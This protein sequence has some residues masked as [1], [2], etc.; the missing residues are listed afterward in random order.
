M[1]LAALGWAYVGQP[2]AS[3]VAATGAGILGA[4][5]L[6]AREYF[7]RHNVEVQGRE[8]ALAPRSVPLERPVGRKEDE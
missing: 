8:A 1:L 3:S 6:M 2:V 7:E 4:V 5:N